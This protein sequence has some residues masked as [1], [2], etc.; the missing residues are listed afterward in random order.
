MSQINSTPKNSKRPANKGQ[1]PPTILRTPLD[2]SEI[3]KAGTRTESMA[4]ERPNAHENGRSL[5]MDI[6]S[7]F[8]KN[9]S[10]LCVLKFPVNFEARSSKKKESPLILGRFTYMERN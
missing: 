9:F 5:L 3:A 10:L 6:N 4:A 1:N 7:L 2:Y 8:R